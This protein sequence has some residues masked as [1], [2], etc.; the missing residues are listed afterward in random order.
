MRG[1]MHALSTGMG[2]MHIER[3]QTANPQSLDCGNSG[4][5]LSPCWSYIVQ[6]SVLRFTQDVFPISGISAT[7]AHSRQPLCNGQA[8]GEML[9]MQCRL[10]PDKAG[11]HQ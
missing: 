11:S 1:L 2:G 5:D 9:P 4:I 8:A 6:L 10:L 7:V 3:G